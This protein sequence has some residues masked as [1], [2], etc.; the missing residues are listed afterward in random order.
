MLIDHINLN[1]IRIFQCVFRTGSM[2]AAAKELHLTQ[3]G[4][5]QHMKTLEDMLGLKL[6]D[7]IQQRIVPTAAAADLFKRCTAGL[8]EIEDGLAIAKGDNH[9]LTGSVAVGMPIEFGNNVVVPLLA[10]L[11]REH[12]GL[13]FK[14]TLEFASALNAMLLKGDIDFAFVDEYRMDRRIRTEEVYDEVLEL[15]ATDSYLKKAGSPKNHR[16]YFETLQ[17]V[18]YQDDQP[19]LRMWFQ[20]HLGTKAIDLNVRFTVMDT[21]AIAR[22]ILQNA[23]V[24]IMPGHLVNKL[25][26]E[27]HRIHCFRGC[28]KPLKNAVSIAYLAERTHSPSVS[29]VLE[30]VRKALTTN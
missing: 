16:K 8:M 9:E 30:Q 6:F 11:S 27:G 7:R 13:R 10:A 20:H 2:T 3:S 24:G 28:G 22:L 15:C 19:L 14:L 18:E 26:R 21:Q 5:S 25:T 29:R 12:P 23:G 17:Y 1:H 4:V